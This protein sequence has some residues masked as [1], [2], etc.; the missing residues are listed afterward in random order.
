LCNSFWG[1]TN[2]LNG[3]FDEVHDSVD[4][5]FLNHLIIRYIASGNGV[6]RVEPPGVPDTAN[7]LA[8]KD[9]RKTP[10]FHM[11]NFDEPRVEEENV[12][13]MESNAISTALPFNDASITT[14]ITL[15][16]DIYAKFWGKV[17]IHPCITTKMQLTRVT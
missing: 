9:L 10:R 5:G 1:S 7:V 3:R 4:L 11:A 2:G 15:L 13:C 17:G 16:I 8:R 12:G 14:R 6:V